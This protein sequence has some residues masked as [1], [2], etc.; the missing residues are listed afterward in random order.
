MDLIVELAAGNPGALSFVIGVLDRN[1]WPG[2]RGLA[3]MRAYGIIGDALY[4]LW[5]D[6]CGQDYDIAEAVM[7]CV[8]LGTILKHINYRNG[9]GIPF[10]EKEII[11]HMK[12]K[13]AWI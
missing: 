8:D 3:R 7:E 2:L 6:C 4:M 9:R 5:N 1:T 12:R 13:S 11:V 10:E